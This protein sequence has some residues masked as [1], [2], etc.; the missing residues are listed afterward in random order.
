MDVS[1]VSTN[2]GLIGV[3]VVSLEDVLVCVMGVS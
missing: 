3:R 2:V 1:D